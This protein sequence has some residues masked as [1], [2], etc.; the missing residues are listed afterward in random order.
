MCLPTV[1][2]EFTRLAQRLDL[3][4]CAALLPGR[5]EAAREQRPLEMFFPFDP[6]LLRHSA[7]HLDLGRTYVHW[8]AGHPLAAP[9]PADGDASDMSSDEEVDA[10][11]ES[12]GESA[13]LLDLLTFCVLFPAAL[14]KCCAVIQRL[15]AFPSSTSVHSAKLVI[16]VLQSC[17]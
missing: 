15:E 11:S 3:M 9:G 8:K 17:D 13:P 6:F 12:S 4:D 7:R 5:S 1:V 16:A 2:A 14:Q 10:V